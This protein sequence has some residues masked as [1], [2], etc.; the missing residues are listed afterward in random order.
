MGNSSLSC[1]SLLLPPW[2][3][4]LTLTKRGP[5][6]SWMAHLREPPQKDLELPKWMIDIHHF[7]SLVFSWLILILLSLTLWKSKR[8][9][10]KL[11]KSWSSYFRGASAGQSHQWATMK[12]CPWGTVLWPWAGCCLSLVMPRWLR[13]TRW[14][15]RKEG[16]APMTVYPPLVLSPSLSPNPGFT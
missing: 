16:P 9:R 10:K 7:L 3:S 14:Q 11:W 12:N 5:S 8:E 1:P 4:L 13:H 15:L 6:G 2:A